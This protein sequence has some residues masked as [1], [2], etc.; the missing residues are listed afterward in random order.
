MR[1]LAAPGG[2]G[3]GGRR[4]YPLQG[5]NAPAHPARLARPPRPQVIECA[6]DTYILD[7]AEE[8]GKLAGVGGGAGAG[9]GGSRRSGGGGTAQL[10]ASLQAQPA[11]AA[12]TSGRRTR[13]PRRLRDLRIA[14][15]A[16]R[17]QLS[18]AARRHNYHA[19]SSPPRAPPR[20]APAPRL[21]AAP[22]PRPPVARRH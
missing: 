14:G 10:A 22:L 18:R 8:A 11:A 21:T 15:G 2:G 20:P 19:V 3:A 9:A 17:R 16:R 13:G 6:E 4:P 7:A 12:S 5:M 1:V